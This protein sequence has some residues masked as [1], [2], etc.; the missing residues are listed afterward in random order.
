MGALLT[1]LLSN[2]YILGLGAAV[3]A[4][5]VAFFKGTMSGAAKERAKQDAERIKARDV[6][7]E[8]DNDIGAMPP[9]DIRE[10]LKTWQPKR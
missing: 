9:K 8:V 1:S 2:P 10:E 5:I 3:I 4:V 7:D 6:A